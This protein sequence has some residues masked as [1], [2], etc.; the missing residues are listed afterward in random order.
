MIRRVR[1]LLGVLT[2]AVL[3]VGLA[4]QPSVAAP[5]ALAAW[6]GWSE[7]PGGGGTP[8]ALAATGYRGSQYVF[9]RGTD[10]RV[11]STATR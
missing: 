4:A 2:L 3:A 5:A 10:N 11:Y 8:D 1:A 9:A 6:S 7:V